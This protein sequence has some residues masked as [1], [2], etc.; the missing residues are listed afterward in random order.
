MKT[1]TKTVLD[2]VYTHEGAKASHISV[3]AQLR[4]SVMSCLLW[5]GEFY[6]DGVTIAERIATLVAQVTPQQA[7]A[8]AI[9]ARTQ[10]HLRHVPLWIAR[11]MAKLPKHKG[12]VGA[13][14]PQIIL[15]ADELS[16]FLALYW[17]DGRQPLSKQVKIGLAAAFQR[18][19]EYQLAK[20]NR[21]NAVKLRDVLFLCHAKPKDAA[22][23]ALWKRLIDDTMATPDTW[24]V[25]LSATKGEGKREEWERL[26]R[27]KKVGGDALL[28]NLR[29]LRALNVDENLVKAAIGTMSTARILPFRFIAA[30]R[31][32][33]QWEA[34]LEQAMYK[35]VEGSGKLPGKTA[36]I[37]DVSGSMNNV[38]SDKSEMTRLEVAYGLAILAR[39]LCETV[40][41]YATA[42]NDGR[43]IHATALVPAR[44]GFALR[45]AMNKKV[46]EL[47]GG[48]IFLAQC[49]QMIQ[50]QEKTADRVIVLTDEQDCDRKL[51]PDKAPAFGINNY[52]VN[53]ASAEHGIAYQKFTHVNG[54]SEAVL[55]YIM[56]LEPVPVS[57]APALPPQQWGQ[58]EQLEK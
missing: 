32:A 53:V 46:D 10:M 40:V 16:E 13:L 23:D 7:T 44:R 29:N 11:T 41:V 28:Y 52:I 35:S 20:Y 55:R 3:E 18:F 39:E 33:P 56:E 45:D 17:K 22:Q 9:E 26:L 6:E 4:R 14:L 1:N 36:L 30:A 31:Y 34:E 43:G 2:P 42:G 25:A 54:W 12:Q 19:D 15:R 49:L 51:N 50:E 58:L 48:G 8:I 27:E 21:A 38:L 5:E 47:G 37:V 24:E 57:V